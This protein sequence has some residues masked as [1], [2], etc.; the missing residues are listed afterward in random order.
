MKRVFLPTFIK[1]NLRPICSRSASFAKRTNNSRSRSKNYLQQQNRG[2]NAELQ[3]P[4]SA[5]VIIVLMYVHRVA[6][7]FAV[8]L[9]FSSDKPNQWFAPTDSQF[10]IFDVTNEVTEFHH[11]VSQLDTHIAAEIEDILTDRSAQNPYTFG[12]QN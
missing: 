6:V 11:V 12:L 10:T 5:P 3:Q 4:S 9:P 8:V 1:V 7:K 2:A